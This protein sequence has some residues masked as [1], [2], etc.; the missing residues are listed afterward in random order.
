MK[1][2]ITAL[3]L[4]TASCSSDSGPADASASAAGGSG[5]SAGAA[6]GGAGGSSA[7]AGSSGKGGAGGAKGG[8][9]GAGGA[10]A[11]AGGAK[12]G[13]G[14]GSGASG[15]AGKASTGGAAGKG[16]A[17]G[18]S[19]T[20]G[21][22]GKASAGGA[23]GKSGAAG[24]GNGGALA[25]G[26]AGASGSGGV[27]SAG[28]G[29][30][31]SAGGSSAGGAVSAGGAPAGGSAGVNSG[32]SS[33]STAGGSGG[34]I[35]PSS[36]R[37]T[38]RPLGSTA[39]KVGFWEYLPPT[40]G[41]G[42]KYPLLVFW[43]GLGEDGNGTSDLPKVL[44]HGPPL[45]ISKDKWP[46]DRPF[47]VLSPQNASGCPSA[48]E[49]HD[50]ITFATSAYSIDPKRV[51]LT[52]LSCGA[53]G[54]WQYI[55]ANHASQIAAA[56]LMSGDPGDPAQP[57]SAWGKSGCALGDVALWVFHGDKDGTVNIA[58]EQATMN[59]VIACPSPP[60]RDAKFDVIVGGGHVIWDP[61]Y[62]TSAGFDIYGFL[63]SNVNP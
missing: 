39:A 43:H 38:Q 19:G 24:S 16:G 37:H 22:A 13:A 7:K 17:S 49:I 9:D 35:G 28:A 21:S 55:N 41:D 53:I 62:D 44:A 54:S 32:G 23:A 20:S 50:L 1:R 18:G 40:Y 29:G 8:S 52:G 61:I 25:G 15:F 47:V 36:S 10:K 26:A 11:G 48:G 2:A 4:L 12:G 6:I 45:V 60:R 33:G 58:N 27:T 63:L 30:V 42:G 31:V 14:G 56:V 34:A 51:Y 46:A 59:D 5:G 3:L 57:S